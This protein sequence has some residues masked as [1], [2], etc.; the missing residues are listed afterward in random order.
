MCVF[1]TEHKIFVN[2]E[3]FELKPRRG[4]GNI[5]KPLAFLLTAIYELCLQASI[6][7]AIQ[8][9]SPLTLD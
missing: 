6:I 1:Y 9:L 3:T 8:Y 7:F 4:A 2:I 5:T